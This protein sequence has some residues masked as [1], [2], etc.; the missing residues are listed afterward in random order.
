MAVGLREGVVAGISIEPLG[1]VYSD[2]DTISLYVGPA[3]QSVYYD[4]I[5][6]THPRRLIFNPGTENP[7]LQ[8][9]LEQAGIEYEEA[10][11]L[12]LLSIGQF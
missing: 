6:S 4:Y 11:T 1:E 9:L 10:C 5:L 3:H 8:H 7:E 12:V 2:I